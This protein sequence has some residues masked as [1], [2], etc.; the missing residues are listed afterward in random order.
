MQNSSQQANDSDSW[1]L[2]FHRAPSWSREVV[3]R[4]KY[5]NLSVIEFLLALMINSR[6]DTHARNRVI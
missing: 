5:L 4:K 3:E 6:I 2:T 1:K